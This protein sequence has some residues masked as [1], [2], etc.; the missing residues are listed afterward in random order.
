M[1]V[2][3]RTHGGL[4]NQLFQ[5]FFGRLIVSESGAGQLL[6]V[7]DDRYPHRF[8]LSNQFKFSADP[9]KW[10]EKALSGIRLPKLVSRSGIAKIDSFSLLG[11]TY[12]DGYFQQPEQYS[13]FNVDSIRDELA[14]LRQEFAIDG[15]FDRAS[16]VHLRLGD[17]FSRESD[18]LRHLEQRLSNISRGSHVISNRDDL[19]LRDDYKTA[20]LAHDCVHVSTAGATSEALLKLMCRYRSIESNNSTLAFWASVFTGSEV[21]FSLTNLSRLRS[22]LLSV[23]GIEGY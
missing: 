9:L 7:H 20:L 14:R 4:G 8:C 13:A 2:V 16:L 19:L 18:E 5:I 15:A 21:S 12:L 3:L 6:V 23:S 11:V 17:F 22:R 1:R 10:N